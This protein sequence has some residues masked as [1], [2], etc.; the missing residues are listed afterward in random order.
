MEIGVANGDMVDIYAKYY[1]N[2]R[3]GASFTVNA[4]QFDLDAM[5][6]QILRV[7]A[8][9]TMKREKTKILNKNF[10]YR[11]CPALDFKTNHR[12]L[13]SRQRRRS[14]R[15]GGFFILPLSFFPDSCIH[16]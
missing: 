2:R 8:R 7:G 1:F 12:I 10:A 5:T 15:D 11:F 3:N 4:Q 6:S 13:S 9:Y 16:Y 14:F